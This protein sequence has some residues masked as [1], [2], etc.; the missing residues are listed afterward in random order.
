[1]DIVLLGNHE[2]SKLAAEKQGIAIVVDTLR[3]STTMPVA[4]DK[5]IDTLYVALEVEDTRLAAK[6]F[7]TLLMGE[8]GCNLL[9][10]FNYGNSPLELQKLDGF[11]SNI[12]SFTSSTGARRI[13]DAIGAQVIIVGSPINAQAVVSYIQSLR[14]SSEI[15]QKT[16][17]I[18][19]AFSEG[20]IISN[21]ITED[22]IGGLI[23]A[24]E[25]KRAG[26]PITQEISEEIDFLENML[27]NQSLSAI[28]LQTKHGQTLIELGYKDDV[29]YCSRINEI[30][31]VPA[32]IND[33]PVLANGIKV[34]KLE[35]FQIK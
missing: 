4:M 20:S 5:G 18:I 35:K 25:F 14:Q 30:N 31:A 16:I 33:T 23:I 13:V 22:Q 10:G 8:R 32:S 6:E 3:A 34:V 15:E 27:K 7:G 1:M 24:R 26:Y 17:V 11:T 19:P 21:E 29:Y 28:L 12:A 2:G 9:E